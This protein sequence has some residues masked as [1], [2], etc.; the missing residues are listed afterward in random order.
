MSALGDSPQEVF[1]AA[2]ERDDPLELQR[3]VLE[4]ALEAQ[5]REWAEVCCARLARHRNANVRGCA[6]Q[7][8]G[9]LARRF[10]QLDR[11]RVQRLIEIGLHAHNEAV[12]AGAESAAED[13]ETY[14]AWRF[15]R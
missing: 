4:V 7:G 14:L 1:E 9:H 8:L 10:G 12:R 2:L 11:R 6:L 5:N 13:T 3:V 15:E